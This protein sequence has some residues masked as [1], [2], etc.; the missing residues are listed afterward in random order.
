MN[1]LMNYARSLV[2][3]AGK[4]IS[5][6]QIFAKVLTSNDDSSRHGVLIPTDAYSYFPPLPIPDL[7]QNATQTF[8]A[9]DSLT[10]ARVVLAYKYYKRYPERRITRLHSLLN[11]VA[12]G[13]RLVVFLQAHHTDGTSG[14]YFDCANSAP[15]GR[16]AELFQL[17]FGRQIA[18]VPGN[19]VVRPVDAPA[20]QSDAP[21][22][23][24]LDRF[25]EVKA[26]GWINSLRT[27]DTGIGYTFEALLGLKENNDQTADFK[28]IEIKCRGVNEGQV[29]RACK[30]NLFQARPT[31]LTHA[32]AR[33]RIRA[34]GRLKANG[35]YA[36]YSQVTTTPNNLGLLLQVLQTEKKIDLRKA[37][38][39]IGYWEFDRLQ[40]RLVEKH[41]RAA[42]IRARRRALKT[43]MQYA[44][45]EFVYCDKPSIQRFVNL[46]SARNIVFEFAMS[47]K[48]DGHVRN[49]G[50]PWRLIRSEFLD[51]LFTFQ[52]K[53]R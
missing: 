45:E 1:D 32:T 9:F 42:F 49:H 22:M 2:A 51:H 17:I 18:P 3:K 24:L 19:F 50:Y 37:A 29:A 36:C 38:E 26:R 46:V 40:K 7:P 47:E 11:D 25:D 6:G 28:G 10:E 5:S 13:P 43:G 27:G 39:A 20:F 31:W 33:E 16:F 44:Y 53:L 15:E 12:R 41:S 14:Y 34:I 4:S 21:L 8:P 30:I 23:E 35:L 52:I 48:P